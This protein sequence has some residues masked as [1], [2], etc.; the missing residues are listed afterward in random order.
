[1]V[2]IVEILTLSLFSYVA[3]E[4]SSGSVLAV[5][6]L[7]CGGVRCGVLTLF[8]LLCTP[9]PLLLSSPS[10]S[11]WFCV[12]CDAAASWWCCAVW[13]AEPIDPSLPSSFSYRLP[14]SGVEFWKGSSGTALFVVEVLVA[15]SC[16]CGVSCGGC[17][18]SPPSFFTTTFP[19]S[20]SHPHHLILYLSLHSIW[21]A[22]TCCSQRLR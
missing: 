3:G 11:G 15:S 4:F 12:C 10:L 16:F 22:T 7:R 8:I 14:L 2:C 5:L 21:V 20:S 9:P 13:R 6:L 17:C 19:F 1:V 18:C